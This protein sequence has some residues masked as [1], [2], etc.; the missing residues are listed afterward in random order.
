MDAPRAPGARFGTFDS[1][2]TPEGEQALMPGVSPLRDAE[3][4]AFVASQ[5]MLARRAK[6]RT[7]KAIAERKPL[8]GRKS[9]PSADTG[10]LFG[11]DDN[12]QK[13]L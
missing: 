8:P 2:I 13:L 9:A 3:R 10:P 11:Y 6:R 4:L 7:L 12:Q 1:E 5:P